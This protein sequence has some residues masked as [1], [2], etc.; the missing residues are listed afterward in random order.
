MAPKKKGEVT[1]VFAAEEAAAD[2]FREV[3]ESIVEAAL[4]PPRTK[5][6]GSRSRRNGAFW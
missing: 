6:K 2:D 3:I 4:I 5:G 1:K